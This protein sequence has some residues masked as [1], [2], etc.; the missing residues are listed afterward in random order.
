MNKDELLQ[1]LKRESR[2]L[3]N[4]A[5]AEAFRA[6]DRADFLADDYKSEAYEDYPIPIGY[7]AS[8]P[9][10]TTTAFMLE[11]LA[12]EEGNHVLLVGAGS[13]WSSALIGSLVGNEGAVVSVEIIPELTARATEAVQGYGNIRVYQA[14]GEMGLP[15]QG[16]YDRI[17][18]FVDTHTLPNGLLAQLKIGG[19]AV[20]PI[21]GTL[22]KIQKNGEFDYEDTQYPG[23]SFQ[24]ITSQ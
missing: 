24:P 14:T 11:L 23:F 20:I 13:G 21:D 7:G 16:P 9:Q 22:Y 3:E 10:P 8:I 17:I 15:E 12:V 1:H 4:E 2:V 19:I 6:V 18:V 5:I